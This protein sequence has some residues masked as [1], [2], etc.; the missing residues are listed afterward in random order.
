MAKET[1]R[2][3]K[4]LKLAN[5]PGDGRSVTMGYVLYELDIVRTNSEI[6]I[7]SMII[8]I[9]KNDS[10]GETQ[11]EHHIEDGP[12]AQTNMF[13]RENKLSCHVDLV[14]QTI[15]FPHLNRFKLSKAYR[16]YGLSSYAMNE[17][18]SIVKHS[19]PDF[20]VD[21]IGFS[22]NDAGADVDRG[23]FF[24]FMEKFGFWF[25]FD[26]DD[27]S[28]GVLNIERA[29]MLKQV[30]K[31]DSIIELEMAQFVRS[32]FAERSRLQEEASRLKVEFKEKNKAFD[33][34]EKDQLITFLL[35]V[36]GALA[37]LLLLILFI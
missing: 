24:A 35:N 1:S 23:A 3:L 4:L 25:N 15:R 28:K 6:T 14:S 9:A 26:G 20:I 22:F 32:L 5:K 12:A 18:V 37:L 30:S 27:N 21:P 2:D 36:V 33:R 17:I 10:D 11:A 7:N 16:G 29:E 19:Y 31:K 8:P 13:K 34:F